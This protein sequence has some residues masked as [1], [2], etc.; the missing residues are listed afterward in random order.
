MN[1]SPEH[2]GNPAWQTFSDW[3]KLKEPKN[4]K[5]IKSEEETM[6]EQYE[7]FGLVQE[8]ATGWEMPLKHKMPDGV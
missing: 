2:P 7:R 3:K 8:G 4:I 6:Q 1:P 5:V